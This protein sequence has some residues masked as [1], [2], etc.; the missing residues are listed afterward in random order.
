MIYAIVQFAAVLRLKK[1]QPVKT[2]PLAF[3][4]TFEALMVYR[5]RLRSHRLRI[6]PHF[7]TPPGPLDLR[8]DVL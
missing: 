6:D 8:V 3:L 7:L 2:F 5:F 1:R 4:Q